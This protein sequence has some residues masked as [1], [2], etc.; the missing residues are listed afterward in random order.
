M[1]TAGVQLL[2]LALALLASAGF[3]AAGILGGR[4]RLAGWLLLA[5]VGSSIARTV[6]VALLWRAG[7]WFAEEKAL[8][9]LPL[10]LATGTVGAVLFVR[11][12]SSA[13]LALIVAGLAGVAGLGLTLLAGYPLT[14]STALLTL[15][16]L[17]LGIVLTSRVVGSNSGSRLRAPAVAA[18]T[19]LVLGGGLAVLAPSSVD[20]GGGAAAAATVVVPVSSLTGPDTPAPGGTVRR[21]TLTARTATVRLPSG[22][23]VAAWTFN[24]QAPGPE[25]TAEQGDLIEVTLTNVDIADGVTLH[26]HGYDVP[27]AEDGA[28]GLTQDAVLPGQT[29]HYR[30]RADQAGTYWYH[31]HEVSDRGVRMGL[32]G[33]LVVRPRGAPASDVDVTLPMHTFDG[34]FEA[35]SI[36]PVRAGSTVR[37]RLVNTD[38]TPR[39]VDLVGTPFRLVAVDGSDLNGPAEVSSVA[40]LVPAGGRYDLAFTMPE[41]AVALRFPAAPETVVPL[42]AEVPAAV[43]GWPVLDLLSY[44]TPAPVPYTLTTPYE[45][46]FSLVLDQGLSLVDGFGFEVNGDA[47]PDVPNE[48]VHYGDRVEFTIVNRSTVVHPWHLHGHRVLILSRDGD[49]PTGSPLWMDSFDVNPGE[50]WQVAT[51]ADNPGVWMNHCHNLAHDGMALHLT[52]DGFS[53]PFHGDHGG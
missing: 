26:W 20:T 25:L 19:L 43:T 36:P 21:F 47:F 37:L 34:S 1:S 30:F 50:V 29:F 31:T 51:L 46:K 7:W 40:V 6:T 2:D 9:T 23:E 49:T 15:G 27:N 33:A 45:R 16:V 39:L 32:F 18:L 5:A 11:R 4:R 10:L 14:A 38:N 12:R 28:P 41:T 24:G 42:S 13:G 35:G 17:G 52:Y 8:L 22:R 53:S 3:L 48:L 44:G